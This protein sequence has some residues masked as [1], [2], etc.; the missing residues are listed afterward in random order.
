[1]ALFHSTRIVTSNLQFLMDPGNLNSFPGPATTN[2]S[3]NYGLSIY[4]NVPSDVSATLVQTSEFYKDAPVWKLTLTPIT[5]TGVSYLMNANNP[6]IGVVTS[7]GGGLAN[8]YTGHSIFFKPTVPMHSSAPIYTHYSNISGWQ[9]YTNYDDM[10]DGWFRAHVIWYDTVTRSDGKYWAINPASATLNVPMI[11]YWAGPFKEDRNDSIFVSNFINGTRT[12]AMSAKDITGNRTTTTSNLTYPTGSTALYPYLNSSTNAVI[13]DS[14]SI[15]DTDTH[16][17]FFMVRFNTTTSYGSNGYS[18]SWDKIFSFNA[19]GSDRSPG[20]WR[21]PSERTLHWRY[22]PGNS[23]CD[24]GKS[25]AGTGDPFNI[26]TWYYVGVTKNGATAT[27]YVNGN[28]VG[29]STVS[30]PKTAGS[31]SIILFEYFPT[32][33]ASLGLIKVYN[34]VLTATQVQ[35]NFNAVRNRY[36]I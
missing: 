24:F 4:N 14:S 7:G 16:S 35:Q 32:G 28:S 25:A 15:L 30:S 21:W 23:G 20:I 3:A 8:R 27:M 36:G 31:S 2:L 5:S 18:G 12:T 1:M 33:L 17:I 34:T 13:T 19:G 26:D 6:G 10:G 29:T 22:D 9:S 11:F